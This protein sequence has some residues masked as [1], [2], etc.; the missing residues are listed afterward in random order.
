MQLILGV[1]NLFSLFFNF[2][3]RLCV[4][5]SGVNE[6]ILAQCETG[7]NRYTTIGF[8]MLFVAIMAVSAATSTAYISGVPLVLALLIGLFY[9][10]FVLA[11]ERLLQ[12]TL[13]KDVVKPFKFYFLSSLRFALII[14][15]SF[16]IT[17]PILH[18]LFR[19]EIDV[20]LAKEYE[21][22]VLAQHRQ[23]IE[24]RRTKL[25]TLSAENQE[26]QKILSAK[27]KTRDDLREAMLRE[28]DGSGGSGKRGMEG[29]YQRKNEEYQKAEDELKTEKPNLESEIA[30]NNT[31]IDK[32]NG[33][34]LNADK[35]FRDA[36]KEEVKK[37]GMLARNSALF[38]L[39]KTD[40]GA[41]IYALGIMFGL[42][43]AESLPLSVKVFFSDNYE[44]QLVLVEQNEI[45]DKER[46]TEL[47]IAEKQDEFEGRKAYFEL[48]NFAR[49]S[50]KEDVKKNIPSELIA[51][52]R[53]MALALVKADLSAEIKRLEQVSNA[54]VDEPISTN[55]EVKIQGTNESVCRMKFEGSPNNFNTS[56]IRDMTLG[57]KE[58]MP[59]G[60]QHFDIDE[61]EIVN[62][63][64]VP[65]ST[66][67]PLLKQIRN[68]VVYLKPRVT[69][70]NGNDKYEWEE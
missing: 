13:K 59:F 32:L 16:L 62:E 25:T 50:V 27:I 63:Q 2:A 38:T 22:R 29:I 17:D 18:F 31:E 69:S 5:V 6:R 36:L 56:D 64:G 41:A 1:F 33:E 67:K 54:S 49:N 51:E 57:A 30:A 14:I 68:Q 43:L 47:S 24:I 60:H 9:G 23:G 10:I 28:A 21:P 4:R 8:V 61:Y 40:F 53:E 48:R 7:H 46:N 39:I 55:V 58:E 20:Q 19:H 42:I 44:K 15:M 11:I 26:L 37:S 65:L 3:R 12:I 52:L 70:K 34:L 35:L 45:K 66:A